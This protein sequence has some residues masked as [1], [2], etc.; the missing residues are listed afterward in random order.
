MRI[1]CRKLQFPP[2]NIQTKARLRP[3]RIWKRNMFQVSWHDIHKYKYI[4]IIHIHISW[5]IICTWLQMTASSHTLYGFNL[6]LHISP[7]GIPPETARPRLSARPPLPWTGCANPVRPR[8][9]RFRGRPAA[10]SSSCGS[11]WTH[12]KLEVYQDIPSVKRRW[13]LVHPNK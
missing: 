9:K 10:R 4:Y 5:D 1:L 8:A 11:W 6:V 13:Y 7:C 3:S 12:R 2:R